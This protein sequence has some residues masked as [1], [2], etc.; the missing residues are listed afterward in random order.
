[1]K[2]KLPL[3]VALGI[4]VLIQ[5]CDPVE[6]E[7]SRDSSE[8]LLFSSDTVK[9]DTLLSSVGS[10]TRRFR[11]Y[12]PNQK[13]IQIDRLFLG[14]NRDSPYG[15]TINGIRTESF[16]N[17]VIF[18]KDSLLVLVDVLIDPMDESLPYLV[19]D[20]VVMEYNQQQ[21]D[22]KLVA[23]G[24]DA[25]FLDREVIECDA[26]WTA[27]KPY[28]LYDTV[29]IAKDCSLTVEPGTRIYID[30]NSAL[31]VAG[32]LLVNGTADSKV[33]IRNTRLDP[34]YEVAP[35]Q[36]N[37]ILFLEGSKDNIIDHALIKNGVI[38]LRVGS[39]DDDADFDLVVSNTSIAHMSSSG[40]LAFNSDIHVYNTEIY[41][42]QTELLGNYIGG[43]Y[44]YEHCT[45]TNAPSLYTRD[46]ASVILSDNLL[47]GD[48]SALIEELNVELINSIIWGELDEELTISVSGQANVSILLNNNIIRSANSDYEELGNVISQKSNFPGFYAPA[49][50][51]YQLDSLASARDRGTPSA[52]VFDLLGTPRD[53]MPDWGAY[54]RKDSLP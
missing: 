8:S 31:A 22:V 39:P 40:I 53:A 25:N 43:N 9:F 42:C 46:Q 27:G 48:G 19:K 16:K 7:I 41:N 26:V 5:S 51:N 29:L 10:I 21:K 4:W 32:T 23:W 36:W 13:A 50:Y 33:I 49:F 1:M 2:I 47:L 3:L 12:N 37:A 17:E 24:Q 54:E 38:G 30:N 44:K 6:E 15:L 52:I 35:G 18:G 11:I 45:F 20:S 34:D 28:V 14:G